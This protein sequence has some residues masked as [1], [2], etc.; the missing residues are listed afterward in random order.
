MKFGCVGRVIKLI[1]IALVAENP[2]YPPIEVH[3]E[4]AVVQDVVVGLIRSN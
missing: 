4:D 1:R 3:G 2:V